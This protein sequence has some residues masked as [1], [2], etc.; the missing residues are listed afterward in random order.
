MLPVARVF[1]YLG[2]DVEKLKAHTSVA[3]NMFG[4]LDHVSDTHGVLSE[5]LKW[6]L[7]ILTSFCLYKSY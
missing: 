3:L 6:M 5:L 4:K 2:I 1:A 7:P